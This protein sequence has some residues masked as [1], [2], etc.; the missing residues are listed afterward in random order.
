MPKEISILNVS[1][2]KKKQA[3]TECS[4]GVLTLR[5]TY[6]YLG[7]AL[8]P[9]HPWGPPPLLAG[10]LP[11]RFVPVACQN[12]AAGKSC[13]FGAFVV[14]TVLKTVYTVN[15]GADRADDGGLALLQKPS[16]AIKSAR[17]NAK[18]PHSSQNV[19]ENAR[20]EIQVETGC[21]D[22]YFDTR[23]NNTTSVRR[24]SN[25]IANP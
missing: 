25:L 2:W 15:L 19:C 12:G 8:P 18:M 4:G 17:S 21:I 23:D 14:S 9:R 24:L 7:E 13:E 22:S 11:D 20:Q 16:N 1:S 6:P 10:R 3:L 5:A